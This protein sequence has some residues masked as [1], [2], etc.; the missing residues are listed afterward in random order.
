MAAIAASRI[1][2]RFSTIYRFC[3]A[4]E[5]L[6]TSLSL[7]ACAK[8]L[9]PQFARAFSQS[10]RVLADHDSGTVHPQDRT[11]FVG[12]LNP[13]STK[14]SIADYF[15]QF[16]AVEDVRLKP[17]KSSVTKNNLFS[18]ALVE[19]KDLSSLHK[20]FSSDK[21]HQIDM[22]NVIV[23]TFKT[24]NSRMLCVGN[25]PLELSKSDLAEHF[26]QFG[27]VESIE[28]VS[29]N[30][31]VVRESYCFVEFTEPSAV[32]RALTTPLQQIGEY[33]VQVKKYTAKKR[34]YIKGKAIID[35]VP[36]S[37]TVEVL[38][39]YFSKFGDLSFV[40][41]VFYHKRGIRRDYAFLGFFDDETVDKV[42]GKNGKHVIS[43]QEILVKRAVSRHKTQD[44]DLKVFVDG[45]PSTVPQHE[46]SDYFKR[47]GHTALLATFR[48]KD[49]IQSCIVMFRTVAEV[50]RVMEQPTHSIGG[51]TVSVKRIGWTAQPSDSK[52]KEVM[53]I[54]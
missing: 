24:S 10:Q 51:A 35:V 15:S 54:L 31:L 16:G 17:M 2:S 1:S 4:P 40:D 42:T 19:F 26:S 3:F 20:V 53:S 39:D 36:D 18:C 23:E 30:P 11:V 12:Q 6:K 5:L 48:G 13:S 43:G 46:V 8:V 47:F 34:D 41:M 7:H 50:R 38:R 37:V 49:Y 33:F 45:I 22:R 25:V 14:Q 52:I 28:F 44:R 21:K 9:E 27:T 32:L 29:N